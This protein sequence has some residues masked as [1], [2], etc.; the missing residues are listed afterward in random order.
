MQ[1]GHVAGT[2]AS[3][4]LKHENDVHMIDTKALQEELIE[5]GMILKVNDMGPYHDYEKDY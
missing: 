1:M 4:S 2:A 3:M 5:E